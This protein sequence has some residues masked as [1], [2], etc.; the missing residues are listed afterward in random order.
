MIRDMLHLAL[1]IYYYIVIARAIFSFV[2]LFKPDFR[3]PDA[4]RPVLEFIYSMTD[5][6]LNFLRRHIPQPAGLPIDLSFIVM[7]LML[8]VLMRIV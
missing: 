8:Q 6:P 2:F 3:P 4:L 7:I 1:V 5:P